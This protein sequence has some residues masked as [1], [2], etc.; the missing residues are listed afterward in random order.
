MPHIRRLIILAFFLLCLIVILRSHDTYT[1]VYSWR[2]DAMYGNGHGNFGP[3][4]AKPPGSNYSRILV[5]PKL[6]S[7][8]I[9]WISAELP[10]LETAV[11][12]VDNPSA[13]FR[14]PKN[15]GHE[16][17]A[18]LTYIIDHYDNLPDTIIFTHPH[19][20]AWHNNIL[21]DLSTPITI[22]RLSDGR[23]ARQGYM[24]LRGL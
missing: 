3:G 9:R 17:M 7:D 24:N 6:Q 8:D 13:K 14:V 2:P 15:K 5:V 4:T 12:E 23:V 20:S 21:L 22:K 16:A 1:A 19:R 11:Y 10:E 18:Y